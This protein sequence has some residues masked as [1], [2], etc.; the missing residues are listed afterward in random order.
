MHLPGDG[1]AAGPSALSPVDLADR[2]RTRKEDTM[3]SQIHHEHPGPPMPPLATGAR[4][5]S[6][7]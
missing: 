2:A 6:A 3:T 7:A 1:V 4:S 5:T